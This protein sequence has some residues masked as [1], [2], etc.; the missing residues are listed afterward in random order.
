MN[1]AHVLIWWMREGAGAEPCIS[2]SVQ[3]VEALVWSQEIVDHAIMWGR[4]FGTWNLGADIPGFQIS[5][6]QITERPLVS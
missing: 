1:R 2:G 5:A 6:C 3:H 4:W